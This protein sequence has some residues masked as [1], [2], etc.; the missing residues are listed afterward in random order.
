MP[1]LGKKIEFYKGKIG[2]H[3]H[4]WGLGQGAKPQKVW[5]FNVVKMIKWLTVLLK[6][7]L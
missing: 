6:K 5:F 2:D 1:F 4:K 7:H 3:N